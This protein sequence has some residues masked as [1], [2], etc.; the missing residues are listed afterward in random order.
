M[1]QTK[2]P[3]RNRNVIKKLHMV[4]CRNVSNK[5]RTLIEYEKDIVAKKK[6]VINKFYQAIIQCRLKF[7]RQK[8]IKQTKK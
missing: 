5:I 2:Q 1:I 4:L 6:D 7:L 8:E 3:Y